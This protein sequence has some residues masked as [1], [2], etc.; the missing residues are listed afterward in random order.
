MEYIDGDTLSDV[1]LDLPEEEQKGAVAQVAEIMR[2]MRTKT[3]FKLIGGIGPDGA[4]CPLVDGIN[5]T[6]GR[7]IVE[8]FGLYNIGPLVFRR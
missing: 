8:S 6:G 2:T 7:G 3:S 1:W 4:S 5:A